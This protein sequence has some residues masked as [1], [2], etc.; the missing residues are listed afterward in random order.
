MKIYFRQKC[1]LKIDLASTSSQIASSN[2][3]ET[4]IINNSS[5]IPVPTFSGDLREWISFRD[6]FYQ[7]VVKLNTSAAE[8]LTILKSSLKG[9]PAFLI[10][11]LSVSE[12]EF[13]EEIWKKLTDHYEINKFIIYSHVNALVNLKGMTAES[14]SQLRKLLNETVDCLDSLRRLGAP[15]DQ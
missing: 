10:K 15:T 11:N 6:L 7:L 5:N 14:D 9:Q 8:K 13:E 1:Q 4:M 12:N 3:K 2:S